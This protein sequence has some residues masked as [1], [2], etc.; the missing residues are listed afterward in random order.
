MLGRVRMPLR[1]PTSSLLLGPPTSHLLRP[2]LWSPSLRGPPQVEV[3]LLNRPP[4]HPG[5]DG[6]SEILV[7]L[8]VGLNYPRKGETLPG[9]WVVLLETCRG[10]R[11]RRARHHL[12]HAGGGAAAFRALDP[13]GVR[14]DRFEAVLTRPAS[15]R[16]YASSGNIAAPGARLATGLPGWALAGQASH[17]LDDDSEFHELPHGFNP[18]RPA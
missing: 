7:R 9:H 14:E 6:A 18:F 16:T 15:S 5:A 10:Q 12:T 17:L 4:A 13:L 2:P 8:P 1:S 11:P 3:L